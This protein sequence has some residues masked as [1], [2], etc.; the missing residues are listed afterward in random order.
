[1]SGGHSCSGCGCSYQVGRRGFLRAAGAAAGAAAAWSSTL[2]DDLLCFAAES[3]PAPAPAEPAPVVDVLFVWPKAAAKGMM[4]WVYG[5][6]SA[7][8]QQ[9][10]F[11][12]VL[13][14]AGTEIRVEVRPRM[15]PVSTP[16][17]VSL[18]L[19]ALKKTPPAGLII[20]CH[21]LTGAWDRARQ[22]VEGRGEIP[23]VVF[24]HGTNNQRMGPP[25]RYRAPKTYVCTAPSVE[26]LG[27]MLRLA[28]APW[29]LQH[30]RLLQVVPGRN[31]AGEERRHPQGPIFVQLPEYN[32]LFQ[33][34][35]STDDVQKLADFYEKTARKVV[36]PQRAAILNAVKHY[37]LIRT[38]VRER[39]CQGVLVGGSICTHLGKTGPACVAI[40]RLNDEG[41]VGTCEGHWRYAPDFAV[42]DLV[43]HL[44]A[45]RPMCMG[46]VSP[47]TVTN[48]LVISH[49]YSPTKLRGPDDE[50]RAAYQLRDAHG[51]PHCVIQVFWPVGEKV[52]MLTFTPKEYFVGSGRVASN[53][54]QPPAFM[55][56]TAVELAVD[57]LDWDT[58]TYRV[59]DDTKFTSAYMLGDFREHFDAFGQL[60]GLKIGP[61]VQPRPADKWDARMRSPGTNART[62]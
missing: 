40:S 18:I 6:D 27:P 5:T 45:G 29:R 54:E 28:A 34:Y 57:G 11:I 58:T 49:C 25:I 14:K 41:L 53:I 55:C 32:E 33:K 2:L 38:L 1:M 31:P 36:E 3:A 26:W 19:E 42:G 47:Q 8:Y 21:L 37:L 39:N 51:A 10:A 35:E 24:G 9:K 50:Y 59:D 56:R 62:C 22:L 16:E 17:D 44:I 12:E 20:C 23:T 15:E 13:E 43:S 61:I 52:T 4:N 46:N 7:R 30:A 48:T 60:T